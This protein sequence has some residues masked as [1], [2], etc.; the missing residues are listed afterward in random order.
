MLRLWAKEVF[1]YIDRVAADYAHFMRWV[2]E[3]EK[4]TQEAAKAVEQMQQHPWFPHFLEVIGASQHDVAWGSGDPQMEVAC[5]EEWR[6]HAEEKLLAATR[7]GRVEHGQGSVNDP[8]NMETQVVLQECMSACLH[9]HIQVLS[10][11]RK[12]PCITMGRW[13]LRRK[14]PSPWRTQLSIQYA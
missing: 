13:M 7:E 12:S 11:R 1:T 9:F 5:W 8:S 10:L 3:D 14:F 6:H 4:Q 2:E